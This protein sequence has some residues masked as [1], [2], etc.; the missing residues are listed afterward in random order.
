MYNLSNDYDELLKLI[1]SGEKVAA[2]VDFKSIEDDGY[3]IQDICTVKRKK[4]YDIAISSRGVM[5]GSVLSFERFKGSERDLFVKICE[6]LNL[7][8][9]K[10][11]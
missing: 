1:C 6:K 10:P 5:Y 8:W 4:S 7:E 2:F 11:C 3:K 9:I